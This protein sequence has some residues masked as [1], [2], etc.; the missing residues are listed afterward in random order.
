MKKTVIAALIAVLTLYGTA[1]AGLLDKAK[2]YLDKDKPKTSDTAA[3]SGAAAKGGGSARDEKTVADGLKEA[4]TIGSQKA[5][6]LVSKQDGYFLNPKIKIPLPEKVQKSERMLRKVGLSKQV[7]EF[8]LTMNRAAEKAA[9]VAKDIFVGAVREMTIQDAITILRGSDTAA[10]EYFRSKTHGKLYAAFKPT[11][12][13]A[14]MDVGVTKAYQQLVDKAKKTK[15]VKDVSL[16]LD[17]HVT[18]KALDGLFY[19]VGEEEKKIRKD[20]VARVTDLLK[21]VFGK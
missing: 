20:P 8:V 1:G 10:T 7:D 21:Q 3:P 19:M 18:S 14:V 13:K 12:S 16:D 4:L 5:V 2:Q 17:H 11:V 9:P 15:I 6:E